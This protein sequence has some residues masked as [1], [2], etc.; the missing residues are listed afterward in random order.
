[1]YHD[2]TYTKSHECEF[3]PQYG[4]VPS[5]IHTLLSL[6]QVASSVPEGEKAA[7]FTSFS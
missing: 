4:H 1:M 2:I 6:L 7:H 5:H 3:V